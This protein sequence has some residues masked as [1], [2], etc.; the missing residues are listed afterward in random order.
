MDLFCRISP[1]SVVVSVVGVVWRVPVTV[2]KAD[3]AKTDI[4]A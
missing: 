1:Q 2:F 3:E 4:N